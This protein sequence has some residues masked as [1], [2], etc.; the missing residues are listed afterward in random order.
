[1][2]RQL[3]DELLREA[4]RRG[5]GEVLL[6]VRAENEPGQALYLGAGFERIAVRRGY[7]QPGAIDA[8]VMRLR[9]RAARS[10]E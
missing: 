3:L 1:M 5:V 8:L 6:E 7:Y 9:L 4:R 10:A 2:G